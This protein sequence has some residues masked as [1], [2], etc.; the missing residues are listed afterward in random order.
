MDT[1]FIVMKKILK[2]GFLMTSA[3]QFPKEGESMFHWKG[4]PKKG[5]NEINNKGGMTLLYTLWLH[6]FLLYSKSQMLR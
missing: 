3:P 2:K 6:L 4:D 5:R 1:S